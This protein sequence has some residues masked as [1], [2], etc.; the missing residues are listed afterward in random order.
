MGPQR[1]QGCVPARCCARR[2]AREGPSLPRA[3]LP[4]QRPCLHPGQAGHDPSGVSQ[5]M[6]HSPWWLGRA[7]PPLWERPG[8][9]GGQSGSSPCRSASQPPVGTPRTFWSL[10]WLWRALLPKLQAVAAAA[11]RN[12]WTGGPIALLG[13]RG[14][15]RRAVG[16]RVCVLTGKRSNSYLLSSWDKWVSRSAGHQEAGRVRTLGAP[17]LSLCTGG[18]CGGCCQVVPGDLAAG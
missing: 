8:V 17:C 14:P 11:S 13:A 1:T 5:T 2:V 12:L 16:L 7:V 4:R 10:L 3:P 15:C 18:R 6:D 9:P